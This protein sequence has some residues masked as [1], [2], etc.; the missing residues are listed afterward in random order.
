MS[1]KITSRLPRLLVIGFAVLALAIS[2]PSCKAKK[3][4]QA[5]EADAAE[6]L[7][8][9]TE[10]AKADLIGL[11]SDNSNKSLEEREAELKAI[12]DLGLKDPEVLDLIRRVEEKLGAER[13]EADRIAAEKAE[14]DRQATLLQAR[15]RAVNNAFSNIANASSDASANRTIASTLELFSGDDAPVLIVIS[16]ENGN[17]DYDRPTTI[18][19]YLE[20]VKDT[21]S[22]EE[23]VG[24]LFFDDSGLISEVELI[25]NK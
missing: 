14:A 17:K 19:K 23:T 1:M 12:K 3:E 18:R 22:V 2:T 6:L 5:A 7:A 13:A 16:E 21:G 4:A 15:Q 8:K 10:Q 25:K 20:H 9:Q 11:L 24:R